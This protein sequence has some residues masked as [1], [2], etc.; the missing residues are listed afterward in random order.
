MR[1]GN[2]FQYF[3]DTKTDIDGIHALWGGPKYIELYNASA[4]TWVVGEAI[5]WDYS[6]A[7]VA[8]NYGLP[9]AGIKAPATAA[10]AR[11]IIGIAVDPV[12]QGARGRVQ[13]YGKFVGANILTTSGAVQGDRLCGMGATTAGRLTKLQET[14]AEGGAATYNIFPCIGYCLTTPIADVGDMFITSPWAF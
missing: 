5:A 2:P 6:T 4:T 11:A 10:G 7:S 8:T 9:A 3:P 14:V 1:Q 13:V 12:V